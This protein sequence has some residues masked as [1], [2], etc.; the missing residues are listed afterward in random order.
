[1]HLKKLSKL[2]DFCVAILIPKMEE[3]MQHFWYIMLY[4]FKRGKNTPEMQNHICAVYGEG[5]R[6]CQ[7]WFAEFRVG[8]FLLDDDAPWLGR[9][10]EVD[11]D[12]IETNI[13]NNQCH[14]LGET[15]DILKI[16]TLIKLLVKMKNVSF[17]LQKK[18]PTR[19]FWPT[20]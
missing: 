20:Q 1:M 2:V 18:T 6:M 13:E 4:Y 14:T 10:V 11:S 17:I 9:P 19:S 8:D 5:D 12:Q 15:A 3:K 16:S 7:K